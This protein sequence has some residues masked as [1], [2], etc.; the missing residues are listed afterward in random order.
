M[1]YF[2]AF[3]VPLI[4]F[5]VFGADVTMT[6]NADSGRIPISPWLFGR[7]N[8]LSDDPDDPTPTA[9]WKLYRDAGLRMLRENGS[10]NCTKYNWRK[11]LSS[12]PDWHNNVYPHD[13][14]YP[15]A[16]CRKA[17]PV[18]RYAAGRLAEGRLR[19]CC[20]PGC[21]R[22]GTSRKPGGGWCAA[23]GGLGEIVIVRRLINKLRLPLMVFFFPLH[24]R[25]KG[26][27]GSTCL[28]HDG[29]Q[30]VLIRQK[31]PGHAG[32]GHC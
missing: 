31:V 7:N 25:C 9:D 5:S 3:I 18:R 20:L 15:P 22:E 16:P 30:P 17:F 1:K 19:C 2:S 32:D 28:C 12:H 4:C 8:S 6:V 29:F 11:K 14:D 13:W 27:N 24:G 21:R 23:C 26:S 10:N